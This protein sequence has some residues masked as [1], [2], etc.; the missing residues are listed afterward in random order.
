MHDEHAVSVRHTD[1]N[2]FTRARREELRPRKRP[3]AELIE[4]EVAVG[5]P[6]ELGAELVLVA[7]RVCST[8][9]WSWS[10]R[11]C[12]GP[13]FREAEALSDSLTQGVRG[14]PARAR[15]MRAARSTD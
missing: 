11:K 15:R 10:V 3:R 8:S 7:V 6:Q 2:S 5:E 12:P 1:A 13:S 9:P 14:S 4:I